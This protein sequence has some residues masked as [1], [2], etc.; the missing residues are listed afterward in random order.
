MASIALERSD[1]IVGVD[2][3]KDEHVAVALDWLGGTLGEPLTVPATNEGYAELLAWAT[4]LGPVHLFAVEG[5][6]SYGIGLARFLRRHGHPPVEVSRPPRKGERR[7]SGKSDAIDAEHAARTA[8]AGTGIVTPKLVGNQPNRLDVG[9]AGRHRPR[10]DA[11]RVQAQ[12]DTRAA[13]WP[14]IQE[15]D[16]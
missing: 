3:H 7:L 2:T 5:C 12:R 1:V 9:G 16:R 8:L 13:K 15:S 11:S 10:Q 4:D 6:G 14:G